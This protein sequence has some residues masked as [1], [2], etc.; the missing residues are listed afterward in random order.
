MKKGFPDEGSASGDNLK[1]EILTVVKNHL[2]CLN[3]N[4]PKS[5]ESSSNSESKTIKFERREYK[6]GL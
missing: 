3:L 5:K 2:E 6:K 1:R 4:Q